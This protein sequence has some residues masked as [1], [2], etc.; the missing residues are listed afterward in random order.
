SGF[1]GDQLP[2]RV[3][4]GYVAG[5]GPYIGH[6]GDLVGIAVDHGAILVTRHR[7]DLRLEAHR[8]LRRLVAHFR[9]GDVGVVD[10]DE[11]R[12]D[13][14]AALLAAF[15]RAL[16]AVVDLPAKQPLELSA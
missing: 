12:L 11:A 4:R 7:D 13:G 16:E 2:V 8:H 15:D 10:R 1:S 9:R 5:E 6:F 3:A 14:L